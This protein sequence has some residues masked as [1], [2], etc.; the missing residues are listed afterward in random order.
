MTRYLEA[1]GVAF[2]GFDHW[3]ELNAYEL[4]AGKA[5]GRPRVKVTRLEQMLQR[6][7]KALR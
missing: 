6:R 5:Q 3:L 1:R 7:G 4:E 2:V